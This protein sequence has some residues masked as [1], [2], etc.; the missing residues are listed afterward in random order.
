MRDVVCRSRSAVIDEHPFHGG[1]WFDERG[2]EIQR[3]CYQRIS[4]LYFLELRITKLLTYV[5]V[6]N[7]YNGALLCSAENPNKVS[8]S[9][10]W[11]EPTQPYTTGFFIKNKKSFFIF[12][13]TAHPNGTFKL[14][15]VLTMNVSYVLN[16]TVRASWHPIQSQKRRQ[17]KLKHSTMQQVDFLGG[18]HLHIW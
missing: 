11:N 18:K 2:C 10:C 15:T 1:K 14:R 17:I 8:L 3:R 9:L 16:R 7:W 6:M 12:F 13:T 4:H 5:T